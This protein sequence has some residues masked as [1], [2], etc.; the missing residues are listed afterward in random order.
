MVVSLSKSKSKLNPKPNHYSTGVKKKKKIL[1]QSQNIAK[2]ST[3]TLNYEVLF[4]WSR[5]DPSLDSTIWNGLGLWPR[6]FEP[7]NTITHI[8]E[9]ST[10]ITNNTTW[11]SC[12]C[13]FVS[14]FQRGYYCYRCCTWNMICEYG[15]SRPLTWPLF[16]PM[17]VMAHQITLTLHLLGW[18]GSMEKW[19]KSKNW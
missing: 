1:I 11:E 13:L 6:W 3:K 16:I 15:Q 18:G 9:A 10:T 19:R 4:P 8:A 7:I 2:A 5:S 14:S 12:I 17:N